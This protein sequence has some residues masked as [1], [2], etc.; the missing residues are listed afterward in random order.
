V[1]FAIDAQF[2]QATRNQLRD[3]RPEVDDQKALVVCNIHG[4]D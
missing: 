4:F 1:N 3:L 2:P